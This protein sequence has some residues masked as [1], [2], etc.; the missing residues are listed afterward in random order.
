MFKSL[1]ILLSFTF[2]LHASASIQFTG[3]IREDDSGTFRIYNRS[4]HTI[5]HI[6]MSPDYAESWG[7]D[8]LGNS[9]LP[10]NFSVDL[11]VNTSHCNFNIKVIACNNAGEVVGKTNVCQYSSVIIQ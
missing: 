7:Q 10:N 1:L 9:T 8:L 3:D 2:C 6:Y 5:C 4:G 11:T